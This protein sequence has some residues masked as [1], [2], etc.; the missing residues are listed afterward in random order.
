MEQHIKKKKYQEENS[1]K[2]LETRT[3]AHKHLITNSPQRAR[4]RKRTAYKEARRVM[5]VTVNSK[6]LRGP[7]LVAMTC[8]GLP[9]TCMLQRTCFFHQVVVCFLISIVMPVGNLGSILPTMNR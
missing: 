7:E 4:K 6:Q 3:N 5:R 2:I 9:C 1:S 8:H